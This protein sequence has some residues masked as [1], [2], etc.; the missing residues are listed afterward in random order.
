[1]KNNHF[2]AQHHSFADVLL[3]EAQLAN[4][5]QISIKK[6]QSDRWKGVGPQFVKIGRLV[7]YRLPDILAFEVHHIQ[8]VSR[9]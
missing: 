2:D 8:G 1:M 5:W 9:G 4:R 6:L 7:R 3:T